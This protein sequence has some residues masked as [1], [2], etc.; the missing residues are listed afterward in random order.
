MKTLSSTLLAA[1]KA[2]LR[3]PAVRCNYAGQSHPDKAA[4]IQWGML[5]WEQLYS[6]GSPSPASHGCC[7]TQGGGHGNAQ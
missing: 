6:A 3:R 7:I 1:Q 2:Q 4:A 5:G